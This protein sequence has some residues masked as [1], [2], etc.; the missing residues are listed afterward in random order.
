MSQLARKLLLIDDDQ[1][2]AE[3][4]GDFVSMH[5]YD[6]I[7][8]DRPSKGLACLA[9]KPDL[10]LLD[11]MLPESDGFALCRDLRESGQSVPVIM[12]TARGDDIDRIQGLQFGADDYLP[13]PFNPLELLARVEAVL[14]RTDSNRTVSAPGRRGL[15]PDRRL[16]I[17][18]DREI[19][20]TP[21][22]YRILEAMTA[23]AG[24]V[25]SRDH[26]LALLDSAGAIDSFDRAIDI[27]ISR[28]RSKVETDPRHRRH[29]ITVRGAGYRFEW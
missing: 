24:R 3:L 1:E 16:L 29:L 17:V 18:D 12:L 20:L 2:L 23:S 7:W 9:E 15:D 28:L 27:H 11:V 22:E 13:K 5:G 19:P 21:S 10:L 26:L 4:L 25:F 6:L 14:R 8:A